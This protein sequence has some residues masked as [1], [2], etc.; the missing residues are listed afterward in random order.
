MSVNECTVRLLVEIGFPVDMCR[1]LLQAAVGPTSPHAERYLHAEPQ[2]DDH[3]RA[4]RLVDT[5]TSRDPE[6]AQ[7]AVCL[8]ARIHTVAALQVDTHEEVRLASVHVYTPASGTDTASHGSMRMC[9]PNLGVA[10]VCDDEARCAVLLIAAY[11]PGQTSGALTISVYPSAADAEALP[12]LPEFRKLP[13]VAFRLIRTP[14]QHSRNCQEGGCSDKSEDA[15]H[16]AHVL[17][18]SGKRTKPSASPQCKESDCS[19]RLA[20]LHCRYATLRKGI[21]GHVDGHRVK[22]HPVLLQVA[23]PT[24]VICSQAYRETVTGGVASPVPTCKKN[25]RACS[26]EAELASLLE[27]Q[28]RALA[29]VLQ[30]DMLSLVDKDREF[31]CTHNIA[32]QHHD[33]PADIFKLLPPE[34]QLAANLA[35]CLDNIEWFEDSA[36][37]RSRYRSARVREA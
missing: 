21:E 16:G 18:G 3:G 8:L 27:W 12:L 9:V 10:E 7:A 31:L 20:A 25:S 4:M 29:A 24:C 37:D 11:A 32:S 5:P 19:R 23:L 22:S 13:L 2:N 17:K 35:A 36:P 15:E 14:K 33:A 28:T 26:P 30:Q 1:S 34:E 6:L